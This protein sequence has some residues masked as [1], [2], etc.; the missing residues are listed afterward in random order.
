M[1][2]VGIKHL[3]ICTIRP[4]NYKRYTENIHRSWQ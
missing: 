2:T 4:S 1:N 3:A